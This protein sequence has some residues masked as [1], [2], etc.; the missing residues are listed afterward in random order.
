MRDRLTGLLALLQISVIS[1]LCGFVVVVEIDSDC[2]L[3][4]VIFFNCIFSA[5]LCQGRQ[6][7]RLRVGKIF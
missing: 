2:I 5:S 1:V 6:I 4:G 3:G 7:I